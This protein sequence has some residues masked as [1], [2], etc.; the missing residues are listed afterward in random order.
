MPLCLCFILSNILVL[1]SIF[2]QS[3]EENS[4]KLRR[5]KDIARPDEVAEIK[6]GIEFCDHMVETLLD[7]IASLKSM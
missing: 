4:G 1:R 7:E 3:Y 2:F 6:D 5:L